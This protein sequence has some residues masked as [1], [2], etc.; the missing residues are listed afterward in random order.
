MRFDTLFLAAAL[1]AAALPGHADPVSGTTS[2][3]WIH[4]DPGAAPIVTT[5]VG[6]PTFTW[7]ASAAPNSLAFDKGPGTFATLTES[8]FKVGK[9]TYFNGTT[10]IGTTPDTIDLALTLNFAEPLLGAIVSDYT[11]KLVTTP[12]TDDPIA[13]ADY[14]Y[15]PTAFSTTSFLIDGTTY[16]VKLAGFENVVGDG[17]L[18]SDN[19]SFHVEEGRT[20]SADLY[21]VVT[22]EVSSVPEP[23]N[24]AL[25]AAGLGLMGLAARR[26]RS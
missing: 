2:G 26:R 19:L 16:N 6:T 15:L 4:P 22:T 13:S 12:N 20:A 10:T 1:G 18:S 3:V 17:F 7:G 23:Q 14:V 11:F 25:L 9:I 8:P 5:G 21:A 24:L